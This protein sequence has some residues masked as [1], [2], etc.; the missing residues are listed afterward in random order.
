MTDDTPSDQILRQAL[1]REWT[2]VLPIL[3]AFV[4][5]S[6]RDRQHAEDVIQ[7]VGAVISAGYANIPE[8]VGFNAWVLGVARNHILKRYRTD[9]RD[10]HL[11]SSEALESL[12]AA[13]ERLSDS[14]DDMRAALEHCVDQLPERSRRIIEMRYQQGGRVDGIAEQLDSTANAISGVLFRVRQTLKKCIERRIASGEV[15]S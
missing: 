13:Y 1:T 5:S 7:E 12:S 4:R 3:S 2:K 15:S 10:R 11:F 8:G 14:S 9:Q 6:V